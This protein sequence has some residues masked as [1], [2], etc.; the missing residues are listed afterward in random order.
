MK[1][2]HI[3]ALVSVTIQ[4]EVQ[5]D[6]I[7]QVLLI[8]IYMECAYGVYCASQILSPCIF[9]YRYSRCLGD[10]S[11]TSCCCLDLQ[12]NVTKYI[13]N[14]RAYSNKVFNE[15]LQPPPNLKWQSKYVLLFAKAISIF[16]VCEQ[17]HKSHL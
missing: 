9:S 14:I 8:T 11:L 15:Y 12:S 5:W 7:L 16:S 1:S 2:P 17:T 13:S 4:Q 6:P 3:L 10:A